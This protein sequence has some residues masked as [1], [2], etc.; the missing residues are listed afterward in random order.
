MIHVLSPR[1][2]PEMMIEISFRSFAASDQAIDRS[3]FDPAVF[4][5]PGQ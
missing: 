1:E 2:A 3:L 4:I 5:R